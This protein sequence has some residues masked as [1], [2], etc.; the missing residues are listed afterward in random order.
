MVSFELGKEREK[1]VF[2]VWTWDKQK[3]LSPHEEL[4]LGHLDSMFQCS[5]TELQTL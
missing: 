4:Y 2:F 1:D 5:T 3:I